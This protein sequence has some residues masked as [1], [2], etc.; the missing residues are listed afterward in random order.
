MLGRWAEWECLQFDLVSLWVILSSVALLY[1]RSMT[2]HV[3]KAARCSS[4]QDFAENGQAPIL[5]P[6]SSVADS[7]RSASSLDSILE[8]A[9]LR[10]VILPIY[11]QWVFVLS[12]TFFTCAGIFIT[13]HLCTCFFCSSDDRLTETLYFVNLHPTLLLVVPLLML[14]QPSLYVHELQGISAGF[15]HCSP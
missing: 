9:S 13:E 3:Q 7:K 8:T 15:Y 4:L 1:V 2:L 14:R 12:M 11:K 6:V 5:S 10:S